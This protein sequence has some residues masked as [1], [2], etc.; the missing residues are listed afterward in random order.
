MPRIRRRARSCRRAR[1]TSGSRLGVPALRRTPASTDAPVSAM[2]SRPASAGERPTGRG[3]SQR[4]SSS[5]TTS[6]WI[7]RPDADQAEEGDAHHEVADVDRVAAGL[8]ALDLACSV[9]QCSWS[10]SLLAD[11]DLADAELGVDAM[12]GTSLPAVVDVRRLMS[13]PPSC[14]AEEADVAGPRPVASTST[15]MPSGTI[16]SISAD[17][18]RRCRCSWPSRSSRSST[19]VRSRIS[20]PA[21][22]LVACLRTSAAALG[23]RSQVACRPS[24]RSPVAPACATAAS[25]PMRIRPPARPQKA[26]TSSITPVMP[27]ASAG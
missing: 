6:V 17:A 24:C 11:G 23:A 9:L 5:S 10:T 18:A 15:S 26:P 27:T 20:S 2:A 13:T 8:V 4:M 14:S 19:S 25:R 16:T 22:K 12:S 3:S 7:R 21:P 1:P